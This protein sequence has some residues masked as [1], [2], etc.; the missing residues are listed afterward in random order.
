MHQGEDLLAMEPFE[1]ARAG[2]FLSFQYP[3]AVPGVQVG[4]FLRKAVNAVHGED[5]LSGKALREA[6]REAM[7]ALGIERSFL[8]RYVNDGFSGGEKKRM[9]MLQMALLRPTMIVLDEV[10]SGLDI[11]ALKAV[12]SGIATVAPSTG[13][14]V[15]THYKRLLDHLSPQ[16]VHAMIDGRLVR[17]GDISLAEDLEERGYD[18]LEVAA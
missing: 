7:D 11:D 2:M 15:I 18:W 3:S 12:A 14:L 6:M 1:R 4:T 9:E 16:F 17:S 5:A 8:A 10:D 13:S